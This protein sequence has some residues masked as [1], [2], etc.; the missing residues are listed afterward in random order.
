[1]KKLLAPILLSAVSISFISCEK[2]IAAWDKLTAQ[3]KQEVLDRNKAKCLTDFTPYYNNFKKTSGDLF[4]QGSSYKRGTGF[5]HEYKVGT[6]VKRKVDIRVWK[7]DSNNRVLYFY[8]TETQLGTD[9]YFLRI[10]ETEN[11]EMIG[12]LLKDQC[13]KAALTVTT[14][15]SGPARAISEYEVSN[16]PN[17]D[18]YKDTFTYPFNTL[19]YFA[20]F[21]LNRNVKTVNSK[22]EIV[23]TAIDYVSTFTGKDITFS[24]DPYNGK[25]AQG[26]FI[27]TQKFC[28][29]RQD[30]SNT[31]PPTNYY[32][33]SKENNTFGYRFRQDVD[34][35]SKTCDDALPVDWSL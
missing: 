19:A 12:D 1:M 5:Y 16:A 30:I 3:E 31:N 13:S 9:S 6:E 15:K 21:H 8:V 25:N 18:R 4:D 27:Y 17:T 14:G 22:G 29:I 28:T 26:N 23:G 2:N 34:D 7:K 24:N 10:S 20:N 33:V 32:R 11:E 35:A